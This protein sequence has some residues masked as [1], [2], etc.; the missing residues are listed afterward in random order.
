MIKFDRICRRLC[1]GDIS[2]LNIT[3]I[4]SMNNYVSEIFNKDI[5]SKDDIHNIYQILLMSNI[6]YNNTDRDLLIL[7]DGIYDLLLELF[8][9]YKPDDTT[10]VGA[11]PIVFS[12]YNEQIKEL[13]QDI[14]PIT[15]AE[16]ENRFFIDEIAKVPKLTIE[17]M[18][19]DGI[20]FNDGYSE[21]RL[22]NTA[23]NYPNLVG[24]LTKAKFVLNKQ[25]KDAGV[26]D[27]P[28]VRIFERDFL[29]NHIK[30]GYISTGCNIVIVAMLKYDGVSVEADIKGDMIIGARSRG[31]AN[32]DLATDLT[33]ILYGYRFKHAQDVD[34]D[35]E[36]GMKFEAIMT[37]SN[38][39]KYNQLT[40]S[41][42]KNCRT[43]ISGLF[44]RKDAYKYRDFITL[45][46]LATSI[47]NIDRLT[48][49]EFMNKYYHSGVLLKYAV[50]EGSYIDILFKLKT[51]VD[52]AEYMRD[53]LDFM[54]DG[55]V[56][57]YLDEELVKIL[58]RKNAI[59]Q[60]QYAIKFNALKKRSYI[61]GLSATVGKDGVITPMIHYTP[62][63][64]IGTT[65]TKS[66]LHSYARYLEERPAIG[67]MADVVYANDVM[68]YVTIPN[69]SYN[70]EITDIIPYPTHCPSCGSE[71]LLSESG[72]NYYCN[73]MNCRE[74]NIR[75]MTD[76][77]A[78]L[79]LKGFA[80]A[81]MDK[82]N[83]TSLTK[84]LDL[85]YNDAFILGPENS[86]NCIDTINRIRTDSIEEHKIIGGLGF[87]G[88]SYTTWEYI[89]KLYSL[90]DLLKMYNT[91]RD[92][93]Y[94]ALVSVKGIGKVIAMTIINEFDFFKKD[95]EL[96]NSMSNI[97]PIKGSVSKPTV[98]FTNC[99]DAEF[100]QFLNTNGY[101]ADDK[102]GVTKTTTYL[103][104]PDE[105]FTG[106]SGKYDNAINNGVTQ[107]VPMNK[108]KEIV[109]YIK[110]A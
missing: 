48:E 5:L 40:G 15:F 41:D 75:R 7:E 67:K 19:I 68:P 66:S 100:M 70:E 6:L 3:N 81:T 24:T 39:K 86:I 50:I 80:Y 99:R 72:K 78:V 45:V 59:N 44:N 93:M 18:L 51:F 29:G 102:K 103:V 12:N 91:Q 47:E 88:M 101:D 49:I 107:I 92:D 10:L 60:Y 8:K 65:H 32:N 33:P 27:D 16:S 43:A 21:R 62:V 34:T 106:P 23:H 25:A 84:L 97:K 36:F 63:E 53:Y 82:L 1:D 77:M 69:N 76:F 17:D 2:V 42:Y 37:N 9:K 83:V 31:D 61:T 105:T 74:R 110:I 108:F 13:K 56:V 109:G 38:L 22:I 71:L 94:N 4:I 20:T 85:T 79:N 46:P 30:A 104:I 28:K 26:F 89:L 58:G 73:N 64:F 55:V 90:S 14:E 54:Y 57:E 11:I 95:L 87:T 98:R 52:E 35:Y 96:I